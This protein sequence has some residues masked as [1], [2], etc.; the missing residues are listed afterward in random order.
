MSARAV[1]PL[2]EASLF[3]FDTAIVPLTLLCLVCV[4]SGSVGAQPIP[5]VRI[6]AGEY[7]RGFDGDNRRE[8]RFKLAHLYSTSQDFKLERPSHRVR[9]SRPFKLG[10]TEVTVGQFRRF[11]EATG[12]VTDAEKSGGAWGFFPEEKD[13]VDRFHVDEAITWKQPGFPQTEDH[14]VVCVSHRDAQ[15]FCAWLTR[16]TGD[17]WRLPT[18]AEWEYACRAGSSDWYCWGTDPDTAYSHANVADGALESAHSRTTSYQRAVKLANDEGDGVVYTA[19]V[20]RFQPNRWGLHDMHGNVWEWCQDRF[21][22]DIYERL[23]DGV[24]RQDRN[25][26][27]VSDPQGPETTEQHKYGDWRVIRGGSWFTAPAMTRCSVRGFAEASD[28]TCYTG[29]RVLREAGR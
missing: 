3:G 23:L 8:G 19:V 16:T 20:A 17:R 25:E 2:P 6:E 10:K 5:L 7:R 27:V 26:F 14:P 28:A 1:L 18:E 24:S 4:F 21:Q 9:I 29:F 22:E 13:A 12:Y 15:A 11:V